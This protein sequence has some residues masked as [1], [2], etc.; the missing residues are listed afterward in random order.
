M[1]YFSPFLA[2]RRH[3]YDMIMGLIQDGCYSNQALGSRREYGVPA[4]A[5]CNKV[6]HSISYTVV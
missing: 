3:E 4:E 2:F 6:L 5:L 1:F